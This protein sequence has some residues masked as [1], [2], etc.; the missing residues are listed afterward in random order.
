MVG[1]S[2]SGR[3]FKQDPSS[4]EATGIPCGN[5]RRYQNR[6]ILR[7]VPDKTV[8]FENQQLG[9][10][11][12]G[13]QTEAEDHLKDMLKTQL[14]TNVT[15]QSESRKRKLFCEPIVYNNS[16]EKTSGVMTFTEYN[17][18]DIRKQK[19]QEL[20]QLGLNQDEVEL[21]MIDSGLVTKN[22][23]RR[24]YGVNPAIE[25]DRRNTIQEK[26]QTKQEQ[27]SQETTFSNVRS[28]SRHALEVEK[29]LNKGTKKSDALTH[30]VQSHENKEDPALEAVLREYNNQ[31]EKMSAR[32]SNQPEH[33][34]TEA[35]LCGEAK[36][37]DN[38]CD[39]ILPLEEEVIKR[40]RLTIDEIRQIPRFKDYDAGP[41][42]QV[43]YLKNLVKKVTEADLQALFNRFKTSE[44]KS[45]QMRLMTGRMK[46][47]AFVTFLDKEV[48]IQ[49]YDLVNG[50]QLYK[51]PIIIQYGRTGK[52]VEEGS[53]SSKS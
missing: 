42:T 35:R 15:F 8:P 19:E 18:F 7:M 33:L 5:P 32:V 39:V 17:H 38:D 47:Q 31:Q 22:S 9:V 13:T 49:A 40:H 16:N 46:G 52:G 25:V 30:L 10:P 48:A 41:P 28:M 37:D 34:R 53:E 36:K 11:G 51:R 27:L 44:E 43:L 4:Y 26:I 21:K 24:N 29:S 6:S 14:Q 50:Y 45:L 23:K 12:K 2:V 3:T 1:G 20:S